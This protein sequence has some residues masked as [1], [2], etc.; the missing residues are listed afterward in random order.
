MLFY[1]G[2][3]CAL[4]LLLSTGLVK[5]HITGAIALFIYANESIADKIHNVLVASLGCGILYMSNKGGSQARRASMPCEPSA[6]RCPTLTTDRRRRDPLPAER[7]E[8]IIHLC[9][10]SSRSPQPQH[11][12]SKRRLGLP[13]FFSR[14][15]IS[16]YFL[17]QLLFF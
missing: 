5:K 16:F 15:S 12:S 9:L 4:H 7:H 2:R 8:N 6:E 1:I 3:H 11:C 10:V 14:I 13:R 17:H